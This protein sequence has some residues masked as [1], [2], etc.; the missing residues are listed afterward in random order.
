MNVTMVMTSDHVSVSRLWTF[1]LQ[2]P[3]TCFWVKLEHSSIIMSLFFQQVRF[4]EHFFSD[5]LLVSDKQNTAPTVTT[6]H[7]CQCMFGTK[8]LNH[9]VSR[10]VQYMGNH[11]CYHLYTTVIWLSDF[12]A[13]LGET[14]DAYK[15]LIK[16]K[17]SK[18]TTCDIKTD[19]TR[20]MLSV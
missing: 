19:I 4:F 1:P 3:G 20:K 2:T 12:A 7:E 13:R 5:V 15:I 9:A 10:M 8:L 17:S 14:R 16:E 18:Y 6:K 11:Q